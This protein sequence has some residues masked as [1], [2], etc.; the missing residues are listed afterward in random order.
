MWDNTLNALRLNKNTTAKEC[1]RGLGQAYNTPHCSNVQMY[2]VLFDGVQLH[3]VQLV[4][5]VPSLS[6][7]P[8][9]MAAPFVNSCLATALPVIYTLVTGVSNP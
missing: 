2:S 4:S 5:S 9:Q 6:R 8:G 1:E 7:A 3:S